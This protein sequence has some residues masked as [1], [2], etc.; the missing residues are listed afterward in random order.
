LRPVSSAARVGEHSAVVWNCVYRSPFC[1]SRSIVGVGTGPP[2]VDEAPKP[3]SSVKMS[4]TFGAPFGAAT[5]F[6]KSFTDSLTVRPIL[7][8][9]G[10]SGRGRTFCAGCSMRA[11]GG[12][13]GGG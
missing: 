7:P 5:S 13:C 1:A 9:N 8:P 2:N 11:C 6:G 3:T 12:A 4:R 10:C